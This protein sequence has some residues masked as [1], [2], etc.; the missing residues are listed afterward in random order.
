MRKMNSVFNRL[1]LV[2]LFALPMVFTAC[3][4]DDDEL[5]NVP[6][7]PKIVDLG[8]PNDTIVAQGESFTITPALNTKEGVTYSWKLDGQTIEAEESYTFNA[9]DNGEH[10]V[11]YK[12]SNE[13]GSVQEEITIQVR[14]Y[15][16]GFYMVNEGR[17]AAS[18]NYYK[19]PTWSTDLISG[20]GVTGTTGVIHDGYLYVTSK[21]APY[22]TQVE[23]YNFTTKAQINDEL[24]MAS[25]FCIVNNTTGVLTTK[26]GAYKVTLPSLTLG[27]VLPELED[28]DCRDICLAGEYLFINCD[29][30]VKVYKASDFTYVKD[31]G[32][33]LTGFAQTIDGNLWAANGNS[34]LKINPKD[35]T[36]NTVELPGELN[37]FYNEWAYS[38]GG[39]RASTTENALYFAKTTKEGW[40]TYGKD[41]YKYN[42]ETGEATLFFQTPKADLSLYY[43]AGINVHPTTGDVYAVYTEDG[44]GDH[45]LNTNIYVLDGKEGTQKEIIDYTGEYWFPSMIVFE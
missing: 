34:L 38:P 37:V 41:I 24:S 4:D 23:L 21:G 14:K 1:C 8:M 42:A 22:L 18:V 25:T 12:A 32:E 33:M 26:Q 35:L 40:S 6:D 45:Y 15:Y 17:E 5:P 39:L 7:A 31:L 36:V 13:S 28:K 10:K 2:A 3:S 11:I 20:L 16:G 44:F 29:K 9:R 27:E 30:T 19:K 43:G